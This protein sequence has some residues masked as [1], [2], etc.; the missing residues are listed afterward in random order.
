M[1]SYDS[2]SLLCQSFAIFLSDTIHKLHTSL[3]I[4]RISSTPH[5]PPPFTPPNLSFFTCITTDEVSKLLSHSPDCDL[6]PITTSLLKQC[7]HILLPTITNIINQSLSTGI[8]PDQFKNCYV[9]PYKSRN[10][11]WRSSK[12]EV[13]IFQ[14]V[15]ELATRFQIII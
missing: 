11:I 15:E 9:H 5:F 7:S 10:S 12:P 13:P 4:N 3:L 14:L 1:P 2:P 8:L 6:D